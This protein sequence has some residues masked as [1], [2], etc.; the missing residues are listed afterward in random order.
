[1][2]RFLQACLFTMLILDLNAQMTFKSQ[3]LFGN[4]WIR[5]GLEY[6]KLKIADDGLYKIS[7][8]Q[9]IQ[10]GIP[11]GSITADRFKLIRFGTETPL[12]RST[13]GIMGN[14][15]YLLFYGYRN[16]ADLDEPLF[17]DPKTLMNREYSLYN[18]TS[19]YYLSWDNVP[20]GSDVSRIS[21][22][23]SSL[24]PKEDYYINSKTAYFTENNFKRSNG[25]QHEIKFPLYD[26]CQGYATDIFQTR[27]FALQTE[28]AFGSG[29]DA[30]FN[31]SYSGYGQDG[32]S[33]KANFQLNGTLID[34]D[35]FTGYQFR[36]KDLSLSAA[37]LKDQTDLK[38][39][40][41][42][43][44]EDFLVVSV[45]DY[46]YPSTFNFN[47]KK[48]GLL[49]F[50]AS[51]TNKYIELEN[52]DGGDEIIVYDLTN[53]FYLYSTRESNGVY[54]INLPASAQK[55]ELL[56]INKAEIKST[57][58]LEK[59]N[60]TPLN[61]GDYD[62]VI[63]YH[64]KLM[65]DGNGNNYVQQYINY[66][67]SAEGGSHQVA[68]INIENL[69]DQFAYGIETHPLA[70]KNFAQYVSTIWPKLKY[71]LIIGKGLDYYSYRK[72]GIDPSYF[73]VPTYSYPAADMMLITDNNKQP[74][75]AFG[76]LPVING[77]ELK[78]YLD[79]VKSH[80]RYLSNTTYNIESRE[81]Q[82]R[83]IHL[84]GGDPTIYSWIS[85]ELSTMEDTIETNLFGAHVETFY[86]QSSNTIEVSN[87]EKLKSDINEGSSI[88]AFMGHSAAIRLDFNLENVDSYKNKDKYHL[89][90]AMGCYAGAM[91]SANRSISEDHN[92]APEKGSIVY[93]ANTTAGYPNILGIYGQEFYHQL[94]SDNYGKSIGEAMRSTF[95]VLQKLG[96]ESL[97]TQAYSTSFNG[98]PAIHININKSQD[99]TVDSKTVTTN[100]SLVFSS[101]KEFQLKFDVV[102]LG[103]YVKDSLLLTI[104]K[105]LPSG[106]IVTIYNA[107]IANPASRSSQTI[108]IPVGGDEA[109][110]YNSLFV[111]LDGR[112]EISEGPL[113]D[114]ENNNELII[115]GQKGYTFYVFG[116]EARPVYPAEFAIVNNSNLKLI[117]DNGNTL[118]TAI[119]YFLEIDTTE[120][121]NSP[122]RKN[123]I[124]KQTGGTITWAPNISLIPNTVY[125]WRTAPDSIGSGVFAWRY[126]SFI[127]LPNSSEGWNQS[128]YFQF[129]KDDLFKMKLQEPER[130]FNYADAYV[131]IRANNGYIELPT[132]IRPRVYVG[133]DVAS[134]Y[135]YWLHTANFSGV[136]I[137]VFDPLTGKM[138]INKSGGDFN[139]VSESGYINKPFFVFKTSNSTERSALMD[140]LQNGIPYNHV[141]IFSTLSQ[142]QYSYYPELWESD[143]TRNLYSVLESFGATSVRNLK[144]LNSVPYIMIYR[145]GRSDFEVKESVGNFTDENEISHSFSILQTSGFIQSKLVGPAKSWNRYLWDS[146]NFNG[147]EDQ[148]EINIYGIDPN[149]TESL[150]FASFT[151]ND[152]SLK[153]ID[154]KKYP[155]LKLEW[156][157]SDTI[158]RTAPELNYWRVLYEGLPDA[159]FNPSLL[160]TKSKDTINQGDVFNVKIAAQNIGSSGMDSLLVKFT[161]V[162]QLNQQTTSYRRF[163]SLAPLDTIHIPFS[164]NTSAV[165]GS[166]K[167]FIE[168]NPNN[169][170]AELY[171]FNNTAIIP[172]F[173]KHDK[174]KPYMEVTFDK[175]KILNDDIVSSKAVIEITLQDENKDLLLND[176]SA[177][178]IKI[179]EP[180]G[181]AQRVYF[182][183]NNV[184]F[185]PAGFNDNKVKAIIKGDFKR[186]GIYTLY[187]S[188]VDGSGNT[189]TDQDYITDFTIVTKSSVGNLL[190]Y[191]N[192]FTTKTRF[193]YTLTGDIQPENYMIQIMSVSGKVVKVITKEELG[194]LTIGTHMTDYEY[195]GTDDFGE[196]LANGVYLY[197]FVVKDKN[198]NSWDKYD[199]GTDQYFKNDFGKMVII[200]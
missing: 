71:F 172:F 118:A 41:I 28:H 119:N 83:I 117:A 6:H 153:G 37:E 56:V 136:V 168:L 26:A 133:T 198:K 144:N 192:P 154:A 76:R 113:P 30:V 149:G 166:F 194:P 109:I 64:P 165:Y 99:Y 46:S 4:E 170:Q 180:G 108:L 191:P 187:V 120:Y 131:E 70:I 190:N 127:Y 27:T 12:I 199:T 105:K 50:D 140:F 86:K 114:A 182:A 32:T 48:T 104:D 36:T 171:T 124:I 116:N 2:P 85:N 185:I 122:L 193:V 87:S 134:D 31:I 111:K 179:K 20:S 196:R 184:S 112:D 189:A 35:V 21:N 72:T 45:I 139:S 9:L 38:I 68:A 13:S 162:N 81:W 177:F 147:N 40:A 150:L 74:L 59:I 60:F 200:R 18:D 79:K 159:A 92:L 54:K 123:T 89:F 135:E 100:P 186:D 95:S 62:Y 51:N 11:V 5:P 137:N 75:Y 103:A 29:P 188:A 132:Y 17:D 141:V 78:F 80:E 110:G 146:K 25:E 106:K 69:Y 155:H 158:S 77:N 34:N 42:G 19:A 94:G 163:I 173:V 93:L 152:V 52:F 175:H 167:L 16:R 195:N 145:K 24:P 82:K 97:L 10:A 102:S 65:D 181:S 96:G 3:S 156:K 67:S 91:F 107:K 176:T 126:S 73:F 53:H 49:R 148:Q 7:Y 115:N 39:D 98:D 44:P 1:M 101:Q 169:D 63:L 14:Q 15:D 33:H 43:N 88:I 57:N 138:W 142:Y 47:Q 157:S 61:P 178:T 151:Q 161:I 8:Q 23:L 130:T 183:Q 84:S 90:M 197:R 58:P 55:R 129:K 121:F 66:R 160:L 143:G 22:D 125:Y 174:R 128:H 164:Y